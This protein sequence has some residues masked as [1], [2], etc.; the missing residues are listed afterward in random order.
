NDG[1]QHHKNSYGQDCWT[2]RYGYSH[3][4][5]CTY[6]SCNIPKGNAETFTLGPCE[7]K[8]SVNLSY[9]GNAASCSISV[10]GPSKGTCGKTS[11]YTCKVTNNGNCCFNSCQ[12][13]CC[14]QNFNCP[15]LSPGQSCTFQCNYTCKYTDYGN[16]KCQASASCNYNG[17]NYPCT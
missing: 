2:D 13:T 7:N 12:I 10:S 3:S 14:G 11:T 8:R 1:Y 6:V 5:N 16:F 17:S 15:S 9:Q 4:Q